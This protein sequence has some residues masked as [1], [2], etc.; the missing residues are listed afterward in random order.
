MI[1]VPMQQW[2]ITHILVFLPWIQF[3]LLLRSQSIIASFW[4]LR[5]GNYHPLQHCNATSA[6]HGG[7]HYPIKNYRCCTGGPTL[8]YGRQLSLYFPYMLRVNTTSDLAHLQLSDLQGEIRSI[9][10]T[11]DLQGERILI[12]RT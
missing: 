8:N 3:H 11:F 4:Q 9:C 12:R 1:N 5:L 10:R 7:A 6:D 2:S